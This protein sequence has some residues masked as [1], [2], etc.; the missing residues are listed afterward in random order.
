M[1]LCACVACLNEILNVQE[2]ILSNHLVAAKRRQ[3]AAEAAATP[4]ERAILFAAKKSQAQEL[5]KQEV[6][7]W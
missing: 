7:S 3:E 5:K 6:Q 2:E 1:T 4:D